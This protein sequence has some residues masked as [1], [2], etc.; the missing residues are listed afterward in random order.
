MNLLSSVLR[1]QM[2]QAG[3]PQHF[4]A[5]ASASQ[6]RFFFLLL[7]FAGD[8]WGKE[9]R[10]GQHSSGLVSSTHRIER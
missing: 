5:C 7:Q 3:L 6:F 10:K 1:P 2:G 8:N 9:T 4:V